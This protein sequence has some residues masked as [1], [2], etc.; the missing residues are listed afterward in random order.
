MLTSNVLSIFRGVYCALSAAK[1]T[2]VFTSSMFHNTAEWVLRCQTYEGGFGGAP[3]MEAHGGYTF[4]GLASLVLLG[5]HRLCREDR[6]LRWAVNRQM[7]MEGGFQVRTRMKELYS[8]EGEHCQTGPYLPGK[9]Q[10]A[11]RWVLFILA[12]WNVSSLAWNSC[13]KW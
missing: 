13:G 4:C 2:N 3:G 10:Q 11:C 7:R 9:D 8:M 6:L 12:W 1:L 5:A